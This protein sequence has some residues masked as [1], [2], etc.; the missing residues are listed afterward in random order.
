MSVPADASVADWSA[1]Q[2]QS[3]RSAL[4]PPTPDTWQILYWPPYDADRGIAAGAG[5]AEYLRV[6]FEEAD[7]PYEEVS[8]DIASYFWSRLDLQS[9]NYPVLAPPAVRFNDV[10]VA[11][12]PV[13]AKFLAVKFG[14]YPA[15]EPPEIQ[16]R[17]EQ[18]VATIHEYI[19]EGR[20]A[21]HPVKNTMSYHQQVEAAKPYVDAFKADRLPRYMAHFERL[22][23]A[24]PGPFFL[25]DTL[26][27]VDLQALVML[28]VTKSQWPDAWP[29][30]PIP[31]LTDLLAR[32]EARPR[33]AAYL[34]SPRRNPFAGD[35]L[36]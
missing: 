27:Y 18:I 17:A 5:R 9:S 15:A 33:I 28:Q 19:A 32:L 25:G 1:Q 35:S 16:A 30:L 24:A 31:N 4:A 36:M 8:V 10:V 26:T 23:L 34:R 11:Q 14:L 7:V 3:G 20:M 29:N 21:F 13:A 2:Q 12:T 6:V 22:F